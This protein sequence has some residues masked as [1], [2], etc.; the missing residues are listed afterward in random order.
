M[1]REQF[2]TGAR[3]VRLGALVR[4]SW[5]FVVLIMVWKPDVA[6]SNTGLMGGAGADLVPMKSTS[7]SMVSEDILLTH[8]DGQWYIEADYVFRN[9][10]AKV[11]S[12]QLGFPEYRC[13]GE[14]EPC[15]D[16]SLYRYEDM[17]TLVRDVVVP[18]RKGTLTPGHSWAPKLGVVW[19]FDVTFAPREVVNIRHT[20]HLPTTWHTTAASETRYVTRTGALW[21]GPIRHAR[22]RVLVP[23]RSIKFNG[24]EQLGKPTIRKVEINGEKLAEV[25]YEVRNF[26]PKGDLAFSFVE[27]QYGPLE[28]SSYDMPQLLADDA[29]V[30]A[31]LPATERCDAFATVWNNAG[32]S[33]DREVAAA[34]RT[35][36]NSL[37]ICEAMVYALHGKRFDDERLNRLFYG[38][39]GFEPGPWPHGFM[40]P[41]PDFEPSWID[42]GDRVTIARF[43]RYLG[44]QPKAAAVASSNSSAP[45]L[46]E[47]PAPQQRGG[48]GCL[49]AGRPAG[50]TLTAAAWVLFRSLAEG[51]RTSGSSRIL[52]GRSMHGHGWPPHSRIPA[53]G[54]TAL[55]LCLR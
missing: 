20:Y 46:A 21:A 7:V 49:G 50:S 38:P 43:K 26:A 15:Q 34:L 32:A 54:I 47:Q 28:D 14:E 4:W 35:G 6:R 12:L 8:R 40:Q 39:R 52:S 48:C 5:L 24:P 30:R 44:A 22:F 51:W 19:L 11:Q 33:D 31:G 1:T 18:Q 16:D 36:T 27:R 13:E 3:L 29:P 37:W 25:T 2:G 53:S 17:Q 9:N 45:A 10:V 55:G 23:L 42:D 41:N